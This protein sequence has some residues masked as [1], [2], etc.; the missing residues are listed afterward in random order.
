MSKKPKVAVH[1]EESKAPRI[2]VDP[3][4]FNDRSPSWQIARME[5][6]DPFVTPDQP[7][8]V[9]L[10]NCQRGGVKH[11]ARAVAN[12]DIG[13]GNDGGHVSST[14]QKD[15]IHSH[16]SVDGSRESDWDK[17]GEWPDLQAQA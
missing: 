14:P 11:G 2:T 16:R 13:G 10:L 5:L 8:T 6:V 4:S 1:D 17:A 15:T 12:G 9:A 7:D 3:S